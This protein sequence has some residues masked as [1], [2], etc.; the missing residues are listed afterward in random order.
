MTN[1]VSGA[2][3]FTHVALMYATNREYARAVAGFLQD[4]IDAGEPVFA[5]VPPARISLLEDTLGPAAAVVEFADITEMGRNPAWIIPRVLAFTSRN[6]GRHVRYVGEPIWPARTNAELREATKH[7]SLI[8]LAFADVDAEILCPYDTGALTPEVI[9]DARRTHPLLLSDD[10]LLASTGY[11]EPF[12]I[13]ASCGFPLP[14]PP[15]AAMSFTYH[16]DLSAVRALVSAR[17]WEA[18]L[19]EV[20]ASDLVLAVSEVAANTLR[21]AQ[22]EGTLSIWRDDLEIVC[23]VRDP[24]V[25]TDPLVGRRRPAPDAGGGHGLW[26]VHQV[27]DLV[28]MRSGAGGTTIRMHMSLQGSEADGLQ[29]SQ[30]GG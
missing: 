20:K 3:G 12:Q 30:A 18:G 11:M 28:E 13:P 16:K 10:R 1:H 8:N 17:A 26:L 22:S 7:E 19:P 14:P 21:H 27:C 4:G 24:G 2:R 5:A 6:S 15:A 25:I 23:E 9:S 29:D